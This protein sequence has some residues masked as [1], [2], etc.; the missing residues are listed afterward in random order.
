MIRWILAEAIRG[1]T[2]V[3]YPQNFIITSVEIYNPAP[4]PGFC[5]VSLYEGVDQYVV[6]EQ[7][8]APNSSSTVLQFPT[9]GI[10]IDAGENL[11]EVTTNGCTTKIHGY[12]TT[13]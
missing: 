5:N 1:Y 13:H 8:I 12:L 3:P 4:G 11:R 2:T 6:R 10:V 9:S 7:W